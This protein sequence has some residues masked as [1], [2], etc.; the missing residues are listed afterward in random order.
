MRTRP[1]RKVRLFLSACFTSLACD[2]SGVIPRDRVEVEGIETSI[3]AEW[4]VALSSQ[5]DAS[6]P[7]TGVV[8]G[9]GVLVFSQ[10]S[11][12]LWV[13]R[14][15]DLPSDSTTAALRRTH[16]GA[17]GSDARDRFPLAAIGT[18]EGGWADFI[19]A[20]ATTIHMHHIGASRV[21]RIVGMPDRNGG[22]SMCRTGASELHAIRETP[23]SAE[24]ISVDY[25]IGVATR[26][27]SVVSL[28]GLRR[29]SHRSIA[30]GSRDGACALLSADSAAVFTDSLRTRNAFR[31]MALSCTAQEGVWGTIRA[32]LVGA[33]RRTP[34][35]ASLNRGHLFV[36][37]RAGDER[38]PVEGRVIDVWSVH[39]TFVRRLLLPF[40]VHRIAIAHGRVY[41]L[42]ARAGRVRVAAIPLPLALRDSLDRGGA[43]EILA[44]RPNA[45]EAPR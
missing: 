7:V 20:R 23:T 14:L 25:A 17:G 37:G 5:V 6:D 3:A 45:V 9:N 44:D 41:T 42:R 27:P 8:A 11:G 38:T 34:C 30:R 19:D 35:D 22:W 29:R 13:I 33:N 36:L 24:V 40:P 18:R 39:G 31:L 16:R 43:P 1:L 10:E 28:S 21:Q 2:G 15:R 12:G 26:R 32:F 4:D